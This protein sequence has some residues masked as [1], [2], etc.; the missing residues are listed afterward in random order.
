M[1]E[2]SPIEHVRIAGLRSVMASMKENL[3]VCDIVSHYVLRYPA[4]DLGGG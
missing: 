2:D 4:V 3:K 1:A